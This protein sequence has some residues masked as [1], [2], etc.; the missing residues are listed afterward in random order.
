M[1]NELKVELT[2]ETRQAIAALSKFDTKTD[3]HFRHR[4][5]L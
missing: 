2:L 4:I 1:A 5:I 3:I